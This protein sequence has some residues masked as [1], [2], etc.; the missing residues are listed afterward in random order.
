[1]DS[2]YLVMSINNTK[3]TNKTIGTILKQ[4]IS[5]WHL[6]IICNN[7]EYL[8]TYNYLKNT[9]KNNDKIS[10][11]LQ[12]NN[13]YGVLLNNCLNLFFKTTFSNLVL[14]NSN[15]QYYPNFLKLLLAKKKGFCLW[16]LSRKI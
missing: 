3:D 9:Y 6:L 1:M 16:N 11:Q 8:Y 7:S 15:D 5:N 13:N 10:F 4:T 2:L 14:I 12:I